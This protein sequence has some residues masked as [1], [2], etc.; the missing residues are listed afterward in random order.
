MQG[1]LSEEEKVGCDAD[2]TAM[3]FESQLPHINK[4][5]SPGMDGISNLFYVLYWGVIGEDFVE[6]SNTIL[7]SDTCCV[8][9]Y[10]GLII[11]LYK[12]GD[13]E[14]LS[15]W[16]PITLLN[17][18]YKLIERVIAQRMKTVLPNLV[19]SDQ[20]GYIKG[21]YI[22]DAA[23]LNED[24]ITHCEDV[25]EAGAVLFIDQ[26]KAFDRVEWEWLNLV[27]DK[28]N[29]GAKFRSWI[30]VLY[31]GACSSVFTNGYMSRMFPVRR[32][33]RQGSP[34]SPYLYILQAEPLADTIRKSDDV[35]GVHITGVNNTDIEVKL[36]AYADDMQGYVSNEA[37]IGKYF[38]ILDQFGKASGAKNKSR[39]AQADTVW[40]TKG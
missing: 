22:G 30:K 1:S 24:I 35:V 34:L 15:N 6:M 2:F 10:M 5:S 4:E 20:C 8:S 23:R 33:V 26:S 11:L 27:L 25:N 37:S 29:F 14:N 38:E 32:G 28:Y 17:T 12:D 9:Q 21:R 7:Q 13:R 19:N 16:R 31:K 3:E 40:S 36:N 18:D 39:Q